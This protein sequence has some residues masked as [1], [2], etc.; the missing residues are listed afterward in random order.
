MGKKNPP[1]ILSV[2]FFH[3]I[4][5][6]RPICPQ[7]KPPKSIEETLFGISQQ[8]IPHQDLKQDEF[9]CLNLNITCPAGL[10]PNSR[11]PVMLWIHGL[12][13]CRT[14]CITCSYFNSFFSVGAIKVQVQD[15]FMTAESLFAGA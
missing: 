7:D 1:I 13:I 3:H 11:L 8:E 6:A 2:F 15:G 12:V 5:L 9:E 10:T 14:I 4:L